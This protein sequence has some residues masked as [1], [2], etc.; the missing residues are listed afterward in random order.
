MGK[1]ARVGWTFVSVALGTLNQV[2]MS[3]SVVVVG[4]EVLGGGIGGSMLVRE[5]RV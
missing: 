5:R 1:S 2:S 4:L 3:H